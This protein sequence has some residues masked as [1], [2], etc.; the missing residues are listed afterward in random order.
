MASLRHITAGQGGR[1]SA[2]G[3]EFP[4]NPHPKVARG[5]LNGMIVILLYLLALANKWSSHRIVKIVLATQNVATGA[6]VTGL[7]S[8]IP[9]EIGKIDK[10][11]T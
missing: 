10:I 5:T 8:T 7:A 4:E 6:A 1:S 9:K 3:R 2:P 11:C